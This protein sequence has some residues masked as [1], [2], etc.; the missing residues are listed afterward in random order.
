[1]CVSPVLKTIQLLGKS[2]D[3]KAVSIRLLVL[4]WQ[5]QD[6]CFPQLLQAVSEPHQ[7]SLHVKDPSDTDKVLL[8]KASAILEICKHKPELHGAEL[9]A[10]LSEILQLAGSERDTAAS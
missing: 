2:P 8:A 9:L 4:L 1:Y 3:L 5:R 7:P 6:R 10:P